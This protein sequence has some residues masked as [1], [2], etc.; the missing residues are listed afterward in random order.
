MN[1]GRIGKHNLNHGHAHV[2]N[3]FFISHTNHQEIKIDG[4]GSSSCGRNW[5]DMPINNT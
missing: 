1:N 4:I 3:I 2:S 5:K